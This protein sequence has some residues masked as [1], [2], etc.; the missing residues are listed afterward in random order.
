M[1]CVGNYIELKEYI[2]QRQAREKTLKPQ[3]PV[4][5]DV[6]AIA[7]AAGAAALPSPEVASAPEMHW[8]PYAERHL[9]ASPWHEPSTGPRTQTGESHI[10]ALKGKS[11]KGKGK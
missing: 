9:K 8:D 11:G 7:G 3:A 5:M 10:Y 4:N 6:S 1:V 2:L